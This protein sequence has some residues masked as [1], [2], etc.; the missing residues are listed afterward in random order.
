MY[1]WAGCVIERDELIMGSCL[2]TQHEEGGPMPSTRTY[3][4][5][6]FVCSEHWKP[7][8]PIFFYLGNE[9]DVLLCVHHLFIIIHPS[10][11]FIPRQ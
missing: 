3:S 7:G 4:Q 9:A 1:L 8:G 5:R 10:P 2:Q 11:S 6:Y